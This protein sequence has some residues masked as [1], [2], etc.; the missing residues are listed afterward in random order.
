M[1]VENGDL[2]KPDHTT[3]CSSLFDGTDQRQRAYCVTEMRSQYRA[4]LIATSQIEELPLLVDDI[5][6]VDQDLPVFRM[7]SDDVN[8]VNRKRLKSEQQ[9]N[10]VDSSVIFDND[11]VDIDDLG[12]C[13]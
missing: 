2:P 5:F 9:D 3:L 7:R 11:V 13:I 4:P 1:L 6:S 8:S 10:N 12:H